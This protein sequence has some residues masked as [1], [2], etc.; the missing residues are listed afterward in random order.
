M[1]TW[2]LLIAYSLLNKL[3][4]I[5][6]CNTPAVSQV[7]RDVKGAG[8]LGMVTVFARYGDTKGAKESGANHD[9]DDVF[10]IVDIVDRLNE[11]S[12]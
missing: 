12:E 10:E 3:Q 2:L 7:E 6:T 4:V 8:Q 5:E 9:I 11:R 1:G